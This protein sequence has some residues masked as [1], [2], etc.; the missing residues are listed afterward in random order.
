MSDPSVTWAV[1]I[2]PIT[3]KDVRMSEGELHEFC[4]KCDKMRPVRSVKHAS[5]TEFV[6]KSCGWQTD[7]LHNEDVEDDYM[8][9]VGSCEGC[10][11][12]LYSGDH[13]EF[14]DQCLWMLKFGCP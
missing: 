1:T 7:F 9:P 10:G 13:K 4:W 5:G 8:E 12:N 14:C 6:C 11:T 3:T 2:Q